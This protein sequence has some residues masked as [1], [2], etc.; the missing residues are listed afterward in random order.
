MKL[1]CP[2]KECGKVWEYKG[3]RKFY[4]SCPDCRHNVKI[5]ESMEE[6]V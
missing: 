1:K 6:L 3:D 4:A 5:K 2:N